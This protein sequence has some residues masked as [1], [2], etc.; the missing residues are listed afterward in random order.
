M[1]NTK[2]TIGILLVI[3]LLFP[4]AVTSAMEK[5]EDNGRVLKSESALT[6]QGGSR[7]NFQ[8]FI[9]V[10]IEGAPYERG[11]QHGYL[12]ASEIVDMITRW[13]NIIHKMIIHRFPWIYK[14]RK[15]F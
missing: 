15:S 7:Y 10:Y 4:A 6:F 1:L 13:S 5:H 8:G 14:I 3:L 2:A 11:F 12:L 9:Y